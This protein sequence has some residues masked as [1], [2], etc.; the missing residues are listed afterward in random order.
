MT[1]D[2][3]NR[4]L[5]QI[6]IRI[7]R[8]P[9]PVSLASLSMNTIKSPGWRPRQLNAVIQ[10]HVLPPLAFSF[11]FSLQRAWIYAHKTTSECPL[12]PM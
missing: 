5:Y 10:T 2:G 4:L 9:S 1:N 6:R 7:V 3:D 11:F 12:H 8:I